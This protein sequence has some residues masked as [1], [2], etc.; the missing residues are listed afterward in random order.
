[1]VVNK[2]LCATHAVCMYVPSPCTPT[3]FSI[4][5]GEL[6]CTTPH[7]FV[8]FQV[9]NGTVSGFFWGFFPRHLLLLLLYYCSIYLTSHF[10]LLTSPTFKINVFSTLLAAVVFLTL[11]TDRASTIPSNIR[12]CQSGTWSAGHK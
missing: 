8:H 4:I 1:M 12:G 3:P 2:F 5:A 7:C 9:N 10:S 6:S 11:L